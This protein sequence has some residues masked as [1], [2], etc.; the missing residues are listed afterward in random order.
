MITVAVA[1]HTVHSRFK[2][3]D[4]LQKIDLVGSG[5]DNSKVFSI[6]LFKILICKLIIKS[7]KL[8][9]LKLILI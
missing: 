9:M 1:F 3:V 6:K 8:L 4:G 5:R 2:T 7:K